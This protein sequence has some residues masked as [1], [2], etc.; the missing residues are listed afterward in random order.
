MSAAFVRLCTCR[1]CLSDVSL[2]RSSSLGLK[3]DLPG[4][5]SR[6]LLVPIEDGNGLPQYVCKPSN[7]SFHRRTMLPDLLPAKLKR[8]GNTS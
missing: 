4:R 7:S 8:T 6:L 3:E 1:V 2:N 5:L